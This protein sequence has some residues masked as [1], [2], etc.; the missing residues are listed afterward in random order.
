MGPKQLELLTMATASLTLKAEPKP[1]SKAKTNRRQM[2]NAEKGMIIAFF[3]CLGCVQAVADL[4]GRPWSTVKIFLTRTTLRN[5]DQDNNPRSGR[6]PLLN[7]QKRREIVAAAKSNRK[8]T[9]NAFRNKFVPGVSLS[10]VDR[11][12]CEANIKKWLAKRRLKIKPEHVIK[13]LDWAKAREN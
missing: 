2:T 12:L 11:V 10:T 9:R 6:P 3:V 13:R 7:R 5:G 1:G 8:M 4:I